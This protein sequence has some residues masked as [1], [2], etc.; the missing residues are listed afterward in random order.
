MT[1]ELALTPDGRWDIDVAGAAAAAREAG[2]AALGVAASKADSAAAAA[3]AGAGL[4]CHELLALLVTAD[5]KSTLRQARQLCEAAA[6]V[7]A[8]WVLTI[9]GGTL[10]RSANDVIARCAAMFTEVG[11]KM[12]VEFSPLG[13]V[14]SLSAGLEVVEAAGAD[15]AGLL[16]DTW[17]FFRGDSTW[18][19]LEQVPL[20]RIAYIQFDDAPPPISDD[21]MRETI[22]RRVLPGDGEFELGRFAS[23]LLD[24][25]WDGLVSIEVLSRSLRELPVSEFAR[26][27]YARS[28]PYWR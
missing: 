4:R 8:E 27:A 28:A 17:H 18:K 26:L 22:H 5:E 1:V 12:A 20:E 13:A 14:T 6:L 19:Q 16:I 3:L 7:K 2:F 10:D 25:G 21:G 11:A 24:R 15:R 23:T 9:F